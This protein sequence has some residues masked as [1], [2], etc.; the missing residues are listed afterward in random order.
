MSSEE[1]SRQYTDALDKH[2]LVA[3][4]STG[5]VDATAAN[6][7]SYDV[8][9]GGKQRFI[10]N[11]NGKVLVTDAI[12][13]AYNDAT[14]AG[15]FGAKSL[16]T[17]DQYKAMDL[18]TIENNGAFVEFVNSGITGI[19]HQAGMDNYNNNLVN[20]LGPDKMQYYAN[21][22]TEAVS[23]KGVEAPGDANM[24]SSAWLDQQANAGNIFLYETAPTSTPGSKDYSNV[25]WTT[26]D[27]SEQADNSNTAAIE[28][29]Y[30]ADMQAIQTKDK[31]LDL[32]IKQL[33]T[34]HQALQTEVDSVKKVIEKNIES[35]FKTFG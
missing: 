25:S 28:A 3:S 18:A 12:A 30:D 35:S 32:N 15:N 4:T 1:I 16:L 10:K 31:R 9:S 14:K 20:V 2:K 22:F 11:A 8:T 7:T 17:G 19:P 26:S 23:S 5:T 13:K 21:L 33:D 27:L 34:E 29:K 24:K 6:L